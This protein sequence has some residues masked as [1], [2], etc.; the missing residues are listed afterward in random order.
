MGL[1]GFFAYI[2]KNFK[3]RL[4]LKRLPN[5]CDHLYI[6][7]NCLFHPQCTAIKE[8]FPDL[9]VDKLEEKMIQ[10]IKNY[11]TYLFN[12]ADANRSNVT[13]VDGVAPIAKQGQQRKR[14]FKAVDEVVIRDNIKRKHNK[15]INNQW[16]STA[17]STGSVFMEKLHQ[18]LLDYFKNKKSKGK[19]IY[20]SYHTA[21]EGEHSALQHIKANIKEG[22]TV[23]IY[24]LDADLIFLAMTSGIE[25]IYLLREAV[26]FGIKAE[27]DELYDP[28]EDVAE[29]LIY[30]PIKEL[31][32][33]FN[34]QIWYLI[35][36]KHNIN[37]KLS[38]STSF[39][40][41][42]V[43]IAFMLGN[44]FLPHFP[45][46]NINKGGMD[47]IIDAYI[48]CLAECNCLLTSIVNKKLEINQVFLNLLIERM[49]NKEERFFR[50][51]L[52]YYQNQMSRRSCPAQDDYSKEVWR[53]DNLKSFKIHDPVKL[54][55]DS[56]EEYKFRYYEHHFGVS[57]HQQEFIDKL[58]EL[59]LEGIMWVGRYYFESCPDWKW[60][61][62]FDNGPFISDVSAYLKRHNNYNINDIVFN[63]NEPIDPMTQLVAIL[64]PASANLLPESYRSL[65]LDDNSPII[66][67]F[68]SKTE[69]DMLHKDLYWQCIPKLP[70]LD[71][72]R[73]IEATAG[74]KLTKEEKK[75]NIVCDNFTF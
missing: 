57:A 46:I 2:Y 41:D 65:V 44:D 42:I 34:D 51:G 21:G 71:I 36:Q 18:E 31:K 64:P 69:L 48:E 52:P 27:K 13:C 61:F 29:D 49:G 22:D 24:G 32:S 54:G 40:N 75:R 16:S 9:T 68:P 63:L 33:A 43:V 26:N 10:R 62:P 59:Y 5:G 11:L 67:M 55:T 39:S 25:N 35:N 47:S 45:S 53:L 72:D 4:L 28:V 17:I 30:V 50:E 37:V 7:A 20:S 15:T 12:F 14:R 66:D 56:A 6:D 73:V 3:S 19:H 58:V 8:A 74:K 1:P 38:S 70:F 23:V 60:Q